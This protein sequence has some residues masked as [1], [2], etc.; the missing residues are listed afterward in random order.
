MIKRII[1]PALVAVLSGALGALVGY[2]IGGGQVDTSPALL[3]LLGICLALSTIIGAAVKEQPLWV[4]G[5]IYRERMEARDRRMAQFRADY[6]ALF[7]LSR[8]N[9]DL[10]NQSAVTA[11]QALALAQAV[12]GRT[13]L[14]AQEDA[15]L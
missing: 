11:D 3:L 15:K 14:V 5:S 4:P 1:G 12:R 9:L 6:A 13:A 2:F 8:G 10:A 7:E